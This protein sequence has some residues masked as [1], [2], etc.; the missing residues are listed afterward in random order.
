[1]LNPAATALLVVYMQRG[2]TELHP[3]ELPVPRGAGSMPRVDDLPARPC[4]ST[5]GDGACKP[6]AARS[7]RGA[8]ASTDPPRG[9]TKPPGAEFLPGLHNRR[10]SAVW[11]KR[12][13]RDFHAYAVTAQHP[14][15]DAF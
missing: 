15:F 9:V 7:I 12:Y 1:M 5:H 11:P 6:L 4:A 8:A 14:G 3:D 13:E 10:F 2:F